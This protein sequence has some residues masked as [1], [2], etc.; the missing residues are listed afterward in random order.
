[1]PSA[2]GLPNQDDS[3]WR[4]ICAIDAVQGT[5]SNVDSAETSLNDGHLM[6]SDTISASELESGATA[7]PSLSP[8]MSGDSA[9]CP[10]ALAGRGKG[11][12]SP[13]IAGV[14]A[15]VGE[16]EGCP[17]R[18]A[19]KVEHAEAA[20]ATA[21][22]R[23]PATWHASPRQWRPGTPLCCSSQL[24]TPARCPSVGMN[25]IQVGAAVVAS[26]SHAANTGHTD[27][28]LGSARLSRPGAARVQV[29]GAWSHHAGCVHC[30][31]EGERARQ[32]RAGRVLTLEL[33][34]QT[35]LSQ[36]V[37]FSPTS[38]P[39]GPGRQPRQLMPSTHASSCLPRNSTSSLAVCHACDGSVRW[40]ALH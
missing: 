9:A 22:P 13:C 11:A 36:L 18:S 33:P 25:T 39:P 17:A 16:E 20:A 19:I 7:N 35:S 21:S 8:T 14:C 28:L 23:R 12:W 27:A 6:D 32:G 5:D 1:M 29:Q 34:L 26:Q 10:S 30:G 4:L 15:V 40:R 24:V 3:I 38:F 37:T 2:C 31:R